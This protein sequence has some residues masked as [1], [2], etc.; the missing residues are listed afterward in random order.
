MHEQK[1][2]WNLKKLNVDFKNLSDILHIFRNIR[3]FMTYFFIEILK[4]SSPSR[5]L[6]RNINFLAKALRLHKGYLIRL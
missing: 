5:M 3:L 6:Q 4:I 2:H 1:P